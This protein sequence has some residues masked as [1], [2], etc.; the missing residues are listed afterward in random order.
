[1]VIL[2]GGLNPSLNEVVHQRS[3]SLLSAL[4]GEVDADENSVAESPEKKKGD[5]PSN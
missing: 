5:S 2:G 1:M 4:T 3:G